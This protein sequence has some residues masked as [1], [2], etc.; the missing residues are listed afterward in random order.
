VQSV[1]SGREVRN[2]DVASGSLS[3]PED[4]YN[5]INPRLGLIY[6]WQP[7]IDLFANVSRLYEAPTT[8]ELQDD[9]RGGSATL[10]AMHGT[11]AEI[12][13]RGEQALNA[14]TDLHWELSLYYAQL[15]DEILSVD[16]SVYDAT[17]SGTS[18]STNVDQTVHAGVEA[19]VGASWKLDGNGAH[20]LD[21]QLSM[22]INEFQFDDDPVYGN[23]ELPAAPGYAVKGELLYRNSNGFFTGPTFDL[24]DERYADFSNSYTID[25]YTLLGWRTGYV[26]KRWEV[27]AELI[28]L[29]D[30]DYISTHSVVNVGSDSAAILYPG[31]PRAAYAGV[32]LQF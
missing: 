18:L 27:Y 13:T 19:L 12:G 4:D 8:F 16:V 14:D 15:N 17:S 28:N 25:S 30:R 22:T 10:D 1:A 32:K 2:I 5:S 11:V 24:V 9:V 6:Q 31:S 26:Q 21:P 20:R 23:N 3:A 29:T 7:G